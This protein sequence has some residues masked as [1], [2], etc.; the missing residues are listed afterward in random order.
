MTKKQVNTIQIIIALAVILG[1]WGIIY[2]VN[3][4]NRIAKAP[5]GYVVDMQPGPAWHNESKDYCD[6]HD[7]TLGK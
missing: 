5:T 6:N 4:L 1:F 2:R 3:Y 7:C